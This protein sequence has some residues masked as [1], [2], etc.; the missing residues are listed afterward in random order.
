MSKKR[1]AMNEGF[2]L[3]GED[4]RVDP[5]KAVTVTVVCPCG[6]GTPSGYVCVQVHE[7]SGRV[8]LATKSIG[9]MVAVMSVDE[10]RA[11]AMALAKACL[12]H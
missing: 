9:A 7:D 12:R 3:P 11:V 10:A 1:A 4:V 8:M 6:C 5:D 2:G